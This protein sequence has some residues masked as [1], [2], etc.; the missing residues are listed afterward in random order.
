MIALKENYYALLL[1]I[2][3][4]RYNPETAIARFL[5]CKGDGRRKAGR[6]VLDKQ[7][8]AEMMKLKQTMTYKELASMYGISPKAVYVRLKRAK[9]GDQWINQI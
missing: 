8:I 3:N 4:Y 2:L 6:M 1:S 7:D 5:N 9:D